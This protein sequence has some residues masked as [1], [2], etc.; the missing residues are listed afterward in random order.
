LRNFLPEAA[1][2]IRRRAKVGVLLV[3]KAVMKAVV[4]AVRY[5][6]VF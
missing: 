1:V 6:R 5:G 3:V 2:L 4:R